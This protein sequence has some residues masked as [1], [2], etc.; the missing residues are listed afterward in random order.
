MNLSAGMDEVGRVTR[1]GDRILREINPAHQA[2]FRRLL[3]NKELL[4]AL[5]GQGLVTTSVAED[6]G[7]RLILEHELIERQ[8]Y[9]AEWS[10][11]MLKDAALLTLQLTRRLLADGMCLKDAHPYNVLFKG[12]RPVF[13]DFGSIAEFRDEHAK[14]WARSFYVE[15]MLPLLCMKGGHKRLGGMVFRLED[16]L[17]LKMWVAKVGVRLPPWPRI[18]PKRC[19]FPAALESL[20]QWLGRLQPDD[21]DT[22]WEDYYARGQLPDLTDAATYTNKER[23]AL[24]FLRE[25]RAAGCTTLVDAA[26]NEGWF[27]RLA[28]AEGYRVVALDYDERAINNLYR[29]LGRENLL[30]QPVVM[31]FKEPTRAHGLNKMWQAAQSRLTS[32]VTLAMAVVH[33][34]AL[35]QGMD[36]DS[37]ALRLK[38]LS[39]RFTIVEFID[40]TDV[41]I[42]RRARRRPW[43]TEAAFRQA[44]ERHFREI[45]QAP[46]EPVTRKVFLYERIR[47]Q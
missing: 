35:G 5:H 28:V 44:M 20:A 11:D 32:D 12:C 15:F 36:F 34:L 4:A 40:P 6:T 37:F 1:Q 31:N 17:R 9:W 10:F 2:F 3:Q 42:Q 43:Y 8:T 46:S 14:T 16:H 25:T 23:S 13:V 18:F 21:Y 24:R 7:S 41:H 26:S 45:A 30:I 47:R 27:T 22:T 38:E 29:K 33:H 39:G 19:G